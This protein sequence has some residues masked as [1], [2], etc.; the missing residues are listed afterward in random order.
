MQSADLIYQVA[1]P[2][3]L[4]R[5]FDYLPPNDAEQNVVPGARVKVPF[6]RRT[7]VGVVVA[8]QSESELS[9]NQLK[10]IT[11][12]LDSEPAFS[13]K[14]LTLLQWAS[15]YYHHPIGEVLASA[16]PALMRGGKP[17]PMETRWRLTT[18]G[19]GLPDNPLSR[20]PRQAELIKLLQR[21]DHLSK[22]QLERYEV[23]TATIRTLLK[24]ELIESYQHTQKSKPFDQE[25]LL[26]EEALPLLSDQLNVMELM[27]LHG[28]HSYLLE[29][30]TGSGKTEIYLQAIAKVLRYGRQALVLVPEISL[31]PQTLQRFEHRF[32]CPIVVLH[33]G[34]SD[35]ERLSAWH[36][37]KTGSAAI[38]IGTRSAVFTP[39]LNPGIIIVDEEHDPSFKQQDGFR[40][41]ARDV[42]VMRANLEQMPIILGSATPSLESLYNCQ[43][44]RYHHLR[45]KGR[46][47]GASQPEWQ[48]V[49]IRQSHLTTG[50]S[51]PVIDAMERELSAGH[52]V[53]VF[54]NRRGFAPTLMCHNCGWVAVCE[55]CDAR[56]TFHQSSHQLVCHHCEKRGSTPTDCPQCHSDQLQ[57]LGQGTERGESILEALFPEIPIIRVDRDT[58]RRRQA[59][60][61]VVT[62][63]GSGKPCILVGTQILAKGHHFPK[64]TLVVVLDADNGLYSPDFRATE[65]LGQLI[66]QVAGRAGRGGIPGS[67][68]IQSH[69]CEHPLLVL[70]TQHQYPSFA[71]LLMNERQLG[72]LP[73]FS[74]MA[75]MRAEAPL[76]KDAQHLL[77]EARRYCQSF[78]AGS[79]TL[80]YLGPFPAPLERRNNRFRYQLL[81]IAEQRSALHR[82]LD[83][84]ARWMETNRAA[85]NIRWSLDIDPQD[86]S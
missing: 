53:L 14:L 35:I 58:T 76:S 43:V 85:R 70:L 54:L 86:M 10:A 15:A 29:G 73:P 18:H 74:N 17:P 9:A 26:L 49:D 63:V 62:R 7:L 78:A 40:Y 36:A 69:H 41:S 6:G 1:I 65:R 38:I 33:S 45:L 31:T 2:S 34:L 48:L 30:E 81:L 5:L 67:V 77:V 3:P 16:L 50:F 84:L 24:K 13:A 80:R 11:A 39:M 71:A 44:N 37:A 23:S 79:P 57:Y 12:V 8:I 52:Q 42:A 66:T 47:G 59:M 83:N 82:I 19:K 56:L 61:D 55:G 22:Q 32:K 4:R 21:N 27:E 46:P 64:V 20:A 60:A 68:M 25:N 72:A 51:K 75:V 28:Y